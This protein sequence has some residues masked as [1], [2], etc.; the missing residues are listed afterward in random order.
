MLEDLLEMRWARALTALDWM[1]LDRHTALAAGCIAVL[2]AIAFLLYRRRPMAAPARGMLW[3]LVLFTLLSG[4]AHV[5]DAFDHSG[6][7]AV[8]SGTLATLADWTILSA[9]VVV[10]PA[11]LWIVRQPTS[12]QLREEIDWQLR[13]LDEFRSVRNE[14][15]RQVAACTGQLREAIM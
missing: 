4:L 12:R 14:L 1:A 2:G 3:L 7:L 9:A 13:T 15:E 11:V 8:L 10:W 6:G 5:I